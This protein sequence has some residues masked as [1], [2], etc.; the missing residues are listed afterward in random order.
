MT[1][2]I[3]AIARVGPLIHE[4]GNEFPYMYRNKI[5]IEYSY[6]LT[7]TT[8]Y[9]SQKDGALTI[10]VVGNNRRITLQYYWTYIQKSVNELF[11]INKI[12]TLE[13]IYTILNSHIIL[14]IFEKDKE[15]EEFFKDELSQP[16]QNMLSE[17]EGES[18]PSSSSP[19]SSSPPPPAATAEP[20][21]PSSSKPSDVPLPPPDVIE[22]FKEEVQNFIETNNDKYQVFA[23]DGMFLWSDKSFD[24]RR[25]IDYL[26]N[27]SSSTNGLIVT[28]M[29]IKQSN[30]QPVSII[31]YYYVLNN[32]KKLIRVDRLEVD[33]STLDIENDG[34]S[35]SA[36]KNAAKTL[37]EKRKGKKN[38]KNVPLKVSFNNLKHLRELQAFAKAQREPKKVK[39]TPNDNLFK[40]F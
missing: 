34:I 29:V 12:K 13:T 10:K 21:K 11:K 19:Q 8:H 15:L 37:A 1:L 2:T 27:N 40:F 23:D 24:K 9:I 3:D 18:P 33:Y 36:M 5:E 39:E 38:V 17:D 32:D 6:E 26:L 4:E 30:E 28:N 31:S 22:Q 14:H 35:S 16:A 25:M 20:D 7:K